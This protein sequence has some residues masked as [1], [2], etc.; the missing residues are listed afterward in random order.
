MEGNQL[1]TI[2]TAIYSQEKK[3]YVYEYIRSRKSK[4]GD[5]GTPYYIGKGIKRRPYSK[6]QKG[7][8][9]PKD[10]N[11]IIISEPINEADAFQLEILKIYLYGRINIGTGCL[12]NKSDG[13]DGSLGSIRSQDA[14][15]R[16]LATRL[17]RGKWNTNTPESARKSKETKIINGTYR[18][19]NSPE[20][21]KNGVATRKKNDNYARSEKSK[22]AQRDTCKKRQEAGIKVTP[23]SPEHI[24]NITA[25]RKANG[26]YV[27]SQESIDKQIKTYFEN[28]KKREELESSLS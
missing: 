4:Y 6:H 23:K 1:M 17:E 7:I 26:S 22:Q 15:E 25:T 18:R 19:P 28:K 20:V 2:Y 24:A 12:R 11:N 10:K 8:S 21:I 3:Y 13:G 9:V 14:I 5:I 16:S 27:R